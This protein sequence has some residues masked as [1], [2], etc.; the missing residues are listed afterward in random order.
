MENNKYAINENRKNGEC[1]QKIEIVVLLK[2]FE[3]IK[4]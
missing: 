1:Y 4:L 2:K 3:K